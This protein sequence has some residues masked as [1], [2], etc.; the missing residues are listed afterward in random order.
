[1]IR[2][3][4]Q[5]SPANLP[6][7]Q[8]PSVEEVD[9]S[10]NH[11]PRSAIRLTNIQRTI[12]RQGQR[13]FNFARGR[14]TR[15]A[16]SREEVDGD[17]DTPVNRVQQAVLRTFRERV[18]DQDPIDTQKDSITFQLPKNSVPLSEIFQVMEALHDDP[19]LSI[20]GY[21]VSQSTLNQVNITLIISEFC[22]VFGGDCFTK[23][24]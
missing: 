12:S 2:V 16:R 19:S 4:P 20:V 5:V 7:Q 22:D 1:M 9:S 21:S 3:Q 6:T 10:A 15:T 11:R 8:H 23:V 13:I 18:A 17:E 14:Q 24:A